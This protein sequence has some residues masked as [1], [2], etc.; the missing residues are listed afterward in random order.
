[1][2]DAVPKLLAVKVEVHVE[3]DPLPLS[4]QVVNAPVT[5]VSDKA[6]VPVG[7][8]PVDDTTVTVHVE[9]WFTTTGL[10]QLTIVLLPPWLTV[11][12]VVPLLPEWVV[13]PG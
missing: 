11:T 10:V 2:T 1:V 13:S 12:V 5:P 8:E 7:V 3:V 4:V 6:T 9:P